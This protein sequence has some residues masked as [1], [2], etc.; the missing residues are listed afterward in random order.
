MT[1]RRYAPLTSVTPSYRMVL[2]GGRVGG[3]EDREKKTR[4]GNEKMCDVATGI[5]GRGAP[6]T[7]V[8]SPDYCVN[9]KY[10][11]A[12]RIAAI[13]GQLCGQIC[14]LSIISRYAPCS[15]AASPGLFKR[16]KVPLPTLHLH[17]H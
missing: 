14:P 16:S 8:L 15:S 17:L 12:A 2:Q 3:A 5:A 13:T 11:I 7:Q 4:Q 1:W 9:A 10:P 6:L